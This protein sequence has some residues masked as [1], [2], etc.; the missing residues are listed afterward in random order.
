MD[1]FGSPKRGSP[2]HVA[3]V[4]TSMGRNWRNGLPGF[5][6]DPVSSMTSG[7]GI[8]LDRTNTPVLPVIKGPKG[9]ITNGSSP[10]GLNDG[11][12][13][14]FSRASSEATTEPDSDSRMGKARRGKYGSNGNE[15]AMEEACSRPGSEGNGKSTDQVQGLPNTIPDTSSPGLIKDKQKSKFSAKASGNEAPSLSTRTDIPKPDKSIGTTP[16]PRADGDNGRLQDSVVTQ[17]DALDEKSRDKTKEIKSKAH[18]EVELQERERKIDRSLDPEQGDSSVNLKDRVDEKV[19][20]EPKPSSAPCIFGAVVP[21]VPTSHKDVR[22]DWDLE[23]ENFASGTSA[24]VYHTTRKGAPAS[25]SN[26]VCVCKV[27]RP[28][29]ES[30]LAKEAKFLQHVGKHPHIVDL[31]GFYHSEKYGTA[32]VL[33]NLQG[34][35]IL[36]LVEQP[37]SEMHVRIIAVQVCQALGFIHSRGIVHRDVKA[38]NVV[39]S[40][41]GGEVKLVDFG[42][43]GFEEDEQAMMTRCGSPGYIAPEVIDGCRCSFV[44]DIFGLGVVVYL[45]IAGRLPFRGKNPHDVLRRNLRCSVKFE[46]DIWCGLNM[47]KGFVTTLMTKDPE[48]RPLAADVWRHQWFACLL[49]QGNNATAGSG[50]APAE[51]EETKE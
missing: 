41:R 24:V 3:K 5:G 17:K 10:S 39:L 48:T 19:S 49:Q 9:T 20:A 47:C 7:E 31:M 18:E 42:L 37:C 38:E 16:S 8:G 29:K 11:P 51:K 23:E 4:A 22:E 35:E 36:Q 12:S 25:S 46:D 15:K 33:E 40:G 32:L 44:A 30:E 50:E 21:T 27:A 6:R 45:L 13:P 2:P 28:G 26:P 34:G 1:Q 14:R 43:A